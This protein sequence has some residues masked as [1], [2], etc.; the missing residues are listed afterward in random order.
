MDDAQLS[1]FPH[2]SWIPVCLRVPAGKRRITLQMHGTAVVVGIAYKGSC[3]ASRIT[4][5]RQ[6]T[7]VE[8]SGSI[9]CTP[10]D[11]ESHTC[12]I[13]SD[14][15]CDLFATLIPEGHL[16]SVA[17]NEGVAASAEWSPLLGSQDTVMSGCMARLAAHAASDHAAVDAGM[18]EV[19]RHL[20]LRLVELTGGGKPDWHDDVSVFDRHTLLNLV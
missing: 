19:A 4:R 12:P 11:H 16:K 13:T 10:A 2:L 14:Y 18:D 20:V 1:R 6:L 8:S 9:S 3:L 17:E 15:G 7:W 5:G